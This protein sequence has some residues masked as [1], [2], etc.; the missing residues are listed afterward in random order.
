MITTRAL[1]T[2]VT[3]DEE[4]PELATNEEWRGIM[5]RARKAHGMTQD[6]LGAKVGLSQV[7]ISK[8]E[9]G[10]SG[11]STHILRICRV[12]DIPEPANF[13][14]DEQRDW[15]QLGHVL[16]SRNTEQYAAA[17]QLIRTMVEQLE[18]AISRDEGVELPPDRPRRKP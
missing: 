13:A 2:F 17:K 14:T 15:W 6:E 8:L 18:A 11:S 5:T 3:Q 9:T 4:M 7:M 10:E 1:I 12:L 16:R